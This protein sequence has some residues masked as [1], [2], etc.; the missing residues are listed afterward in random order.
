MRA[1][2]DP[3]EP[4]AESEGAANPLQKGGDDGGGYEPGRRCHTIARRN[5]RS[6]HPACD[7]ERLPDA[8][9]LAARLRWRAEKSRKR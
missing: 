8:G 3:S 2:I 6:I 4:H 5:A 1:A 7:V 9:A